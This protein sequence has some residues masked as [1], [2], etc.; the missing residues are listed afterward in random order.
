MRA[1]GVTRRPKTTPPFMEALWTE[2]GFDEFLA[3]SDVVVMCAALTEATRGRFG[4]REFGLMKPSSYFINMCRGQTVVQ[5]DL[6]AALESGSIA[7][8]GLDVTDPEPLPDGSPLWNMPNVIITPH[9]SG[10]SDG[11]EER[12]DDIVF[13]NIRRF[14]GGEPLVNVVDPN[15]GY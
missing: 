14:A 9:V 12:A 4:A 5:D 1:Y 10:L 2:E 11:T 13:E 15:E 7:G 8:A 3:L 6:I